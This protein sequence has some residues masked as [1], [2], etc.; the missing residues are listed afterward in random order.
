[1][2]PGLD[3]HV[4]T[5]TYHVAS[6]ART[7]GEGGPESERKGRQEGEWDGPWKGE[8]EGC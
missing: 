2:R 7:V 5:L 6:Q 8:Q 3:P 4:H 1:M